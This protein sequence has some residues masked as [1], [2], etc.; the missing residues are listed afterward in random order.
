MST[1]Y[2]FVD[3]EKEQVK[4]DVQEWARGKRKELETEIFT[5]FRSHQDFFEEDIKQALNTFQQTF[6][7]I[8]YEYGE[9][10]ICKTTAT[11]IKF[12]MQEVFQNKEELISF[13]EQNK[14][15]YKCVDEYYQEVDFYALLEEN[16]KLDEQW[17]SYPF[18]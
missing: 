14:T 13:Y 4:L 11:V 17:I 15:T 3:R 16:K 6:E 1:N 12:E 2:Y 18:S 7:N 9:I 5:L 8:C 10:H